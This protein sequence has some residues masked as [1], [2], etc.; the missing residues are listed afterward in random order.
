MKAG[1]GPRDVATEGTLVGIF[2]PVDHMFYSILTADD[3]SAL[4]RGWPA[5]VDIAVRQ[6]ALDARATVDQRAAL[7]TL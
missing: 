5:R 4:N 7:R 6:R 1:T 2:L 3:R